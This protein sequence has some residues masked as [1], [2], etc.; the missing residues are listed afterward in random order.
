M[1]DLTE[2]NFDAL[3]LQ[4]AIPVLVDFWS[5]T[6]GPCRALVPVLGALA[7]ANEGDALI[8]KVNVFDCP[9]LAKKYGVNMLPALLIFHNGNVAERMMGVQSQEKL[10]DA[11]DELL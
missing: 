5:P 2:S 3:V 9:N 10:Q 4:S 7:A 11:L 6:C 8:A 1:L